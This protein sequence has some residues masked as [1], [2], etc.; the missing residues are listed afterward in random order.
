MMWKHIARKGHG[1]VDDVRC[2]LRQCE[3]MMVT[4]VIV[5]L[6]GNLYPVA[7]DL[8]ARLWEQKYALR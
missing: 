1:T 6:G 5:Q 3:M 2:F 7:S 8:C 4:R